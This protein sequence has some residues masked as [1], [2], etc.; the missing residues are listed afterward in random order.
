MEV[1]RGDVVLCAARGDYGKPRPAVVVQSACSIL[2]G[3][4][5]NVGWVRRA[6]CAVT[7]QQC[8]QALIKKGIVLL[9]NV[10][11]VTQKPL[12]HPTFRLN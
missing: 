4:I 6:V 3:Y 10:W 2:S 12:T 11:W 7:H 8:R 5:I 1:K 9:R